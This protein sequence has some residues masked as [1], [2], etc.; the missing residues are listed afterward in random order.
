[1]NA[2]RKPRQQRRTAFCSGDRTSLPPVKV[3]AT[4]TGI[5]VPRAS[6]EDTCHRV[7]SMVNFGQ[8]WVGKLKFTYLKWGLEH[9]TFTYAKPVMARHEWFRQYERFSKTE[10]AKPPTLESPNSVRRSIYQNISATSS[11][12]PALP[13]SSPSCAS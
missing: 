4:N 5:P 3:G 11:K 8:R 7:R 13:A 9:K 12:S 2:S 6:R 1:M 10:T